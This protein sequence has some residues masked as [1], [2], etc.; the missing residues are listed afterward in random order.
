MA[1][2]SE[3]DR[4]S[5]VGGVAGNVAQGGRTLGRASHTPTSIETPPSRAKAQGLPDRFI[6]AL[7]RLVKR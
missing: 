7:T 5:D 4:A 6:R 1:A 2:A 3:A